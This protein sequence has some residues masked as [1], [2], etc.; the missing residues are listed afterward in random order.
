MILKKSLFV[1]GTFGA[2]ALVMSAGGCSSSNNP[3]GDAAADSTPPSDSG[4][5]PDTGKMDSGGGMDTGPMCPT[6]ADVSGYMAA[7]YVPPRNPQDKCTSMQLQGYWDNCLDNTTATMAKCTTF[8]NGASDCS[9]CLESAETDAMYGPLIFGMGIVFLNI[10]GCVHLKGDPTCAMAYEKAT[11]CEN[12]GCEMQCPVTDNASLT[13][14]N[15]CVMNVAMAGCKSY[16]DQA[17]TACAPGDAASP[18]AMCRAAITDFMSGYFAFAPMFC[19][20]G[21]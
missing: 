6:P 13:L 3:G 8:R 14:Y 20:G 7:A 17:N 21:S 2:L 15:K 19:G 1:A 16:E 9:K 11:G 10:A 4:G 5:K 18:Y 12:L